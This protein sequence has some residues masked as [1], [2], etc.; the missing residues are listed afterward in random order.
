MDV[1]LPYMAEY[2]KSGRAACKGCK[3]AIPMKELRIAVLVQSAFHDA[4]VPNWFHKACFFKKQRPSSVGD[5]QNYENLRFDD[6]KE[7]ETLI[8]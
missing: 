3:S 4:K 5:I 7:L 8:E 2:A 6:Q 1:E